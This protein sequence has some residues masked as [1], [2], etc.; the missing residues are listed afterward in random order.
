MFVMCVCVWVLHTLTN[1]TLCPFQRLCNCNSHTGDC[2]MS[3]YTLHYCLETSHE[4][5]SSVSVSVPLSVTVSVFTRV[6]CFSFSRIKAFTKSPLTLMIH[7]NDIKWKNVS[8]LSAPVVHESLTFHFT[9]L[10]L[11]DI[12]PVDSHTLQMHV[13]PLIALHACHDDTQSAQFTVSTEMTY[14]PF[15]ERLSPSLFAHANVALFAFDKE[16]DG[17]INWR[18]ETFHCLRLSLPRSLAVC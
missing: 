16:S 15:D 4:H 12:I 17:A 11:R 18:N 6:N 7:W 8:L 2:L 13:Y 5:R 3:L 14:W 9:P 10:V 1:A